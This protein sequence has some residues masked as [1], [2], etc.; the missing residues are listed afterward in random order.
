MSNQRKPGDNKL[1]IRVMCG[2]LAALIAIP[3]LV[4]IIQAL[5]N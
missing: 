1:M 4:A 3:A 2:V 5:A